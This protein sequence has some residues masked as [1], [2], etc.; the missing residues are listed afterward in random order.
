M[1]LEKKPIKNLENKIKL[2]HVKNHNRESN[3]L[4]KQHFL[5]LLFKNSSLKINRFFIHFTFWRE[6]NGYSNLNSK[7]TKMCEPISKL[8]KFKENLNK[9]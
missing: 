7:I 6:K 2:Q 3:L 1:H 8:K 5:N 4:F 9:N